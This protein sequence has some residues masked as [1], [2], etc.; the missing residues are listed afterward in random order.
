MLTL[1]MGHHRPRQNRQ[2]L[3]AVAIVFDLLP[4]E[5]HFVVAEVFVV[6]AE[7]KLLVG[8]VLTALLFR[9]HARSKHSRHEG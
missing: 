1:R 6:T 4:Q 8:T 7:G 3:P 5:R 9:F 2:F